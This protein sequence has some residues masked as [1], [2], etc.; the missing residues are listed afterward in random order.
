MSYWPQHHVLG[1]CKRWHSHIVLLTSLP[2]QASNNILGASTQVIDSDAEQLY[3]LLVCESLPERTHCGHPLLR[4][5]QDLPAI[6][7]QNCPENSIMRTS[8]NSWLASTA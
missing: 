5:Q 7:L 3:T 6:L 4:G 8:R 2:A 1:H